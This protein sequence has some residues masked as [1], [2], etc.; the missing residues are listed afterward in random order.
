MRQLEPGPCKSSANSSGFSWNSPRD[1][2]IG[3]GSMTPAMSAVVIIGACRF[4][5]SWASGTSTDPAF[6][7]AAT[8]WT[9]PGPGHFPL[10]AK[11]GVEVVVVP[12]CGGGVPGA[13]DAAG[14]RVTGCAGAML[15]FQPN[16]VARWKRLPVPLRHSR[17][18]PRRRGHLPKVCPPAVSATVSSQDGHT[19][20]GLTNVPA[21]CH[22]VRI[23]VGPSGLT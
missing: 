19:A 5:V 22:R 4:D 13:F 14:D 6:P 18:R 16:P 8:A 9:P 23:G 2:F 1:W 10:V 21:R 17:L 15:F 11:Q 7:W 20:K 3:A 12:R